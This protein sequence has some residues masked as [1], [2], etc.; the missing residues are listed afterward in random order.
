MNRNGWSVLE[1]TEDLSLGTPTSTL[2]VEDGKEKVRNLHASLHIYCV[3][4]AQHSR[5][6]F[7]R[8]QDRTDKEGD[9]CVGA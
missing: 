6:R 2:T 4:Q 9:S 1:G 5:E 8:S 7:F 3:C